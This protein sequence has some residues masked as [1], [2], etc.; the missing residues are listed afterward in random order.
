MKILKGILKIFGA[1]AKILVL[2]AGINMLFHYIEEFVHRK[3]PEGG[4]Y[5]DWRHGKVFYHKRGTGAPV[6]I[7]HGFEPYHSG[8]DVD[9]LSRHLASN[10]SVYRV[11][12]LGFGLSDKPWITYTNYLYVVQ[13]LDFIHD[14]IG[15]SADI[16][17][18]GGSGLC[19]L[20][21]QKEM[22]S[23][24]GKIVLVDPCYEQRFRIPKRP[25]LLLRRIIDFPVI[26]TFF[27]NLYSLF[28]KAPFDKEGRHVFTSRLCG[29]LTE[30]LSGHED[31]ITANVASFSLTP[32]K[33]A[34]TYGDVKSTLV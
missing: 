22:P 12:L 32:D 33:A 17:A 20:Q 15:E 2:I 8:K 30:D 5:F 16:I 28:S 26:G 1:A 21:A 13:I 29:Y 9:A 31:L 6:V 25:A 4:R 27:Y 34:F 24:V 10:H 23:L 7:L 11:D 18:C 3:R 19:A 14:V